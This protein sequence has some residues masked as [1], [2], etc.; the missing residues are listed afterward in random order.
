MEDRDAWTLG[1]L[2]QQVG[3]GVALESLLRGSPVLSVR[4]GDELGSPRINTPSQGVKQKS[5]LR[6]TALGPADGGATTVAKGVS[7]LGEMAFP[8]NR[9]ASLEKSSRNP[10]SSMI[11]VGRAANNDVWL[12]AGQ[13]S[14]IHA[15]LFPPAAGEGWVLQDNGSTNGTRLDGVALE[16]KARVPLAPGA[17]IE[18]A[19]VVTHFLDEPGLSLILGMIA[20]DDD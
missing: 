7:P 12:K 1:G 9:V 17:E 13:V 3:A 20:G 5:P 11:T 15:F 16:P 6:D 2:A 14:K 4:L 19:G 8:G 18:F 10:F